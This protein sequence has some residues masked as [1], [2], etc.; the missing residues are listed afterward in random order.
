MILKSSYIFI[1]SLLI[2][3]SSCKKEQDYIYELNPVTVSQ[4]G[5][6]KDNVKSTIE[7]ISIAYSDLFGTG[8]S[9]AELIK[10]DLAYQSFGD[11][12]LIEDMIIRNFLNK[13]GVQL[14]TDAQMRS[15]INAFILKSYL[16]F[17][18]REAQAFEAWY[19]KDLIEKNAG[20]NPAMVY[21]AMM[22][23]NEYR[24]Y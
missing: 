14:P 15:D 19:I 24:Y 21:Y 5:S 22:T 20:I 23:S 4:S 2:F 11:R 3:F 6:G 10:L 18:N 16:K 12:K 8:I 7:F 17:F 13:P 1:I 9:S